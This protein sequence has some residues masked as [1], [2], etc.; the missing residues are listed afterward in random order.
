M[1]TFKKLVLFCLIVF[2]S[3]TN[4]F[5]INIEL[6]GNRLFPDCEPYVQ[7]G[8]TMVPVSVIAKRIGINT[9]WDSNSKTVIISNKNTVLSLQIDNPIAT[10]NNNQV[11]LDVPARIKDG[12]TMVP[13]SFLASNLGLESSWNSETKTVVLKN[14]ED[15]S[16]IT[17]TASMPNIIET[18]SNAQ[19]PSAIDRNKNSSKND[20][21]PISTSVKTP[22]NI[23]EVTQTKNQ[24]PT[25]VS[26]IGNLNSHVFHYSDCSSVKKMSEKNKTVLSSKDDALNRSFTPC[27]RCNP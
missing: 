11:I 24:N 25:T 17:N 1:K 5:A 2:F 21:T 9:F 8:R 23:D 20:S 15:L 10:V 27:K 12:R 7:D 22:P 18:Q 16:E 4:S 13:L 6:N 3:A 26:Y 14:K 19:I